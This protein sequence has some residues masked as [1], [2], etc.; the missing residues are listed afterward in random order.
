MTRKPSRLSHVDPRGRVRMV[1]VGAKAEIYQ[2][3][4]RLAAQ[5]MAVVVA[6]S[7]M[8]ELLGLCH[9]VAVMREGRVTAEFAAEQATQ[10]A[11]LRAATQ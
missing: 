1:D 9:R 4:Q 11:I 2:W 5:G 3:I 7:E 6:S 8:P 10:E